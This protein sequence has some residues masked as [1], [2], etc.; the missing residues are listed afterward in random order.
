MYLDCSQMD[1]GYRAAGPAIK[2]PD[3]AGTGCY[4]FTL[5]NR[6]FQTARR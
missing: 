5:E 3:V 2:A 1:R 6:D 4:N